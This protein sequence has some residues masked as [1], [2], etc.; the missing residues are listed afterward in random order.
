MSRGCCSGRES[1]QKRRG[2][3]ARNLTRPALA[4]GRMRGPVI[5]QIS[6]ATREKVGAEQKTTM[7]KVAGCA[8][9]GVVVRAD[10]RGR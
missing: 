2:K 3:T 8:R 7:N 10:D 9:R 1:R 5:L 6:A 4:G